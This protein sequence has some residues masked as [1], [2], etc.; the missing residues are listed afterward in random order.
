[1]SNKHDNPNPIVHSTAESCVSPFKV[2]EIDHD[3]LI[4][5]VVNPK[6]KRV[7]VEVDGVQNVLLCK[8]PRVISVDSDDEIDPSGETGA[9]LNDEV[10]KKLKEVVDHV[11]ND[12]ADVIATA[13]VFDE[14]AD[15]GVGFDV[16]VD[17]GGIGSSG[18]ETDRF[19]S[20]GDWFG[21]TVDTN[22]GYNS[23]DSSDEEDEDFDP[24]ENVMDEKSEAFVN[25][26]VDEEKHFNEIDE[27]GDPINSLGKIGSNLFQKEQN[28]EGVNI[29]KVGQLNDKKRYRIWCCNEG[30]I[31]EECRFGTCGWHAWCSATNDHHTVKLRK[32]NDT[33]TCEADKDDKY[34]QA[35]APWVV[36]ELEEYVRDHLNSKPVDIYNEIYHRYGHMA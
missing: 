19:F 26:L 2:I 8:K 9:G 31:G 13:E 14:G 10:S 23:Y 33:Y 28:Q 4:Y 29:P 12:W 22:V 15:M 27:E 24:E 36:D 3:P 1:M 6:A 32:F 35:R 20:T 34:R 18:D 30:T 25:G 7:L 17:V 16:E 5:K 11:L 21:P